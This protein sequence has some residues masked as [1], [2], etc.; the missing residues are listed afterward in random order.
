RTGGEAWVGR[1]ARLELQ[2]E[3]GRV[4][5]SPRWAI[6]FKFPPRQATTEVLAIEAQVG[7]TGALTPVA[8]LRP[9]HVG[10]VTVTSASLHNQDEVLRKDVRIGD[11]VVVQRAGDVIPQIVRVLPER[12]PPGAEPWQLPAQCPV[13]R[14]ATVRLE[15][16][17]VTR[18]PNLDC[19]AQLKNNL[20]HLAQRGALDI[21]GLGE[22]LVDQLVERGLVRRLS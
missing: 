16:E 17:A 5:R 13:C 9:V 15:G 3:P 20:R 14:A 12:R 2:G 4:S 6:A 10:G 22:K 19:P 21:E 18:C 11:S 8:K 1:V 7:R